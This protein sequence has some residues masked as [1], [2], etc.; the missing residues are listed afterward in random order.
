MAAHETGVDRRISPGH[1]VPGETSL[2][3]FYDLVFAAGI[4]VL[5]QSF[6]NAPTIWSAVWVVL[7]F[8]MIWSLWLRTNLLLHDRGA[9]NN[10]ARALLVL[11]MTIILIICVAGGDQLLDGGTMDRHHVV[12]PT[13]ALALLTLVALY[14]V[15]TTRDG[16]NEPPPR[17]R[18]FG[19]VT[20]ALC[21]AATPFL[22]GRFDLVLATV[23]LA[24]LLVPNKFFDG[25]TDKG[26]FDAAH[27]VERFGEFT[28]IV[29]GETFVKVGL[30]ALKGGISRIDVV[31]L[32]VAI[33]L[34]FSTWWLYFADVPGAAVD[35]VSHS[36]RPWVLAHY[37]LHLSAVALAIGCAE[38]MLEGGKDGAGV[39]RTF[40]IPLVGVVLSLAL[41]AWVSGA[42]HRKKVLVVHGTGA[43]VLLT[44]A[45]VGS[46]SS[47]LSLDMTCIAM[48]V[49]MLGIVVASRPATVSAAPP[50][51]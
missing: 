37:P 11:Q 9:T 40:A 18:L 31:V 19:Y 25:Y 13:F 6:S 50:A 45:V 16:V 2:E 48:A 3:L 29:L 42:P 49:V 22:P 15:T 26:R 1:G 12:G 5:S 32:P 36:V 46:A 21:F 23:G 30:T 7:V 27:V 24:F 34:V 33:V 8:T 44:V 35:R 47:V 43:A 17:R 38:L 10:A 4:V 41:L 51:P 14:R 39:L 28:I 20:V